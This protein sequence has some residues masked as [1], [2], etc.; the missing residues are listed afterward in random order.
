M[1][2]NLVDIE[3]CLKEIVRLCGLAKQV[4]AVLFKE[5]FEVSQIGVF[6]N[7]KVFLKELVIWHPK[8]LIVRAFVKKLNFLEWLIVKFEHFDD[9]IELLEEGLVVLQLANEKIV[10]APELKLLADLKA[11]FA[12]FEAFVNAL[13]E[14]PIVNLEDF[15]VFLFYAADDVIHVHNHRVKEL[16]LVFKELLHEKHKVC[17]RFITYLHKLAAI[18]GFEVEKLVVVRITDH[19]IKPFLDVGK[20]IKSTS[21]V[22]VHLVEFDWGV[23]KG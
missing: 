15:H 23:E 2:K 16:D 7:S 18:M 1:L 8:E 17:A 5:K 14:N 13:V 19:T 22:E 4:D 10:A 3:L 11:V 12:F 21:D 9:F 6:Q 20:R